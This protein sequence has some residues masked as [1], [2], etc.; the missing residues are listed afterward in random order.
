MNLEQ[1]IDLLNTVE[2]SIISLRHA[3]GIMRFDGD[4][5]APGMSWRGRGETAAYLARN[6]R[7]LLTDP[8]I[9]EAVAS[10]LE[11]RDACSLKTLRRAEEFQR[12]LEEM[13]VTPPEEV[14][15]NQK[16]LNEASAVWHAAKL[17]DDFRAF[18]PYL[19]CLIEMRRRFAQRL[20]ASRPVYDVLLDRYEKGTD[21]VMLDS[22][23]ALLRNELT[24]L[25]AAVKDQPVPRTEFLHRR[26]PVHL[27]RVFSDRV[28]ALFG[29]DR[30][31]CAIS[32]TEH[33]FTH[34]AN[35]WDVRITTHYHEDDVSANLYSVIHE[36][37]HAAYE[38]GVAD[39]L[40][41][42]VLGCGSTMS[43]HESQSRFYE[44]IIGRSEAFCRVLFPI[45]REIFPEQTADVTDA[46]FYHAVNRSEP[47]LIRTE[48]DELTYPMHVLVRYE[49]EKR[50]FAGDVRVSELPGLWRELYRQ[51]LGIEVP[52]DRRGL[53]QDSHWSG[54]MFGYFPSYALGSAYGVQ[55]LHVMER[56]VPVWE[57]IAAGDLAQVTHWLDEHIHRYGR[58]LTPPEILKNAGVDPFEPRQYVD[59]L[60]EKYSALYNLQCSI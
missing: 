54:A 57:Q 22:F 46:E 17:A 32:E 39:D 51:Y 10:V 5:I 11:N 1:A 4:T 43:I 31:R 2:R 12:N 47:S 3:A 6:E 35:K 59:Y 58:L 45:L 14:A 26:Y 44:N 15:E 19:E 24:P 34:W 21:M 56:D 9:Q 23:F 13:L 42:S 33:P 40:Q 25:I 49:I 50:I 27:Q 18:A 37:G 36:C 52:D 41:F 55:M 30:E 7:D 16:L 53:L 48:A 38:L 29:I 28:M 8:A 20:D 60:K